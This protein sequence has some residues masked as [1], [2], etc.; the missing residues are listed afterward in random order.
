MGEALATLEQ[1][2]RSIF[3]ARL[4]SLVAYGERRRAAA[5]DA[6][7]H[8]RTHGHDAPAVQTMITVETLTSDDLRAC[9]ARMTAWHEAGLATPLVIAGH[10]FGRSL[11]AFPLEFGAIIADHTVVSGANPFDGMTVDASD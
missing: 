3:G 6:H 4:Q 11:D 7:G 2:L 5:H 10:E 9:A 8:G 1:E